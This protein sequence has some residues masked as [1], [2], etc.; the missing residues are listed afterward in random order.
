M[1][2]KY[3]VSTHCDTAL[4]IHEGAKY[5]RIEREGGE[6]ERWEESRGGEM[7]R[8]REK[9]NEKEGEGLNR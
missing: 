4:D 6:R 7:G 3:F 1:V 8:G 9:V 5:I 2:Q